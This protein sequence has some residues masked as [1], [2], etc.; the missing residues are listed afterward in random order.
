MTFTLLKKE[1]RQH[2]LPFL[3]LFIISFFAFLILI[4]STVAGG[5]KTDLTEVLSQFI[6]YFT[7]P[8]AM[9]LCRRL[10]IVEY[11]QRTHFFLESL[12]LSRL[13]F[14]LTKY[15]LGLVLILLMAEGITGACVLYGFTI[16][17]I[18]PLFGLIISL[19]AFLFILVIYNFFFLM[20][21]TGRYRFVIY[22]FLYM[23]FIGITSYSSFEFSRIGP[24]ALVN[25]TFAYERFRFPLQD[26]LVSLVIALVLLA[27]ALFLGLAREGSLV[28]LFSTKMSHKEKVILGI[29]CCLTAFSMMTFE[30]KKKRAPFDVAGANQAVGDGIV[31]KV[32][33]DPAHKARYQELAEYL[34]K[35]LVLLRKYLEIDTLKPVFI[36]QNE[37]LLP[38]IYEPV[39]LERTD[40]TLIYSNLQHPEW[41][42]KHFETY[43]IAEVLLRHTGYQAGK[44]KNMWIL[45]GFTEYWSNRK[46]GP[47]NVNGDNNG[48]IDK[49]EKRAAYGMEKKLTLSTL[50][51]WFVQERRAGED[52]MGAVGWAGINLL[53]QTYPE[54]KVRDYLQLVL[55]KAHSLDARSIFTSRRSRA[56]NAYKKV[57]DSDYAD[58]VEKWEA[59]L[60]RLKER[61]KKEL[62]DLPRFDAELVIQNVSENSRSAGLKL[63]NRLGILPAEKHFYC[64][65]KK[66]TGIKN[67][68]SYSSMKHFKNYVTPGKE[69]ELS[70]YFTKG[71]RIDYFVLFYLDSLGCYIA[72]PA[73]IKEI[74]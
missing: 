45:D 68:S 73:K 10:V 65:Y 42:K 6:T 35:E 22:V 23:A 26:G 44:E 32:V 36:V 5:N 70:E 3:L 51:T 60:E 33:G 24:F 43:L 12:P 14:F 53:Y 21:Y 71:D 27:L 34:H 62:A 1:F 7:I 49:L 39:P 13:H 19:R 54:E 67:F 11:E 37:S 55:G 74:E 38:M 2:Y 59:Y 56:K 61:H 52:I 4:L 8:I 66:L 48:T 18:D 41:D 17:H 63:E 64:L 40:G 16:N 69:Y 20:A 46:S 72:S 25:N 31:V 47:D 15:L 58:F 9:V 50:G 30:A 28:S 57:F 29:I